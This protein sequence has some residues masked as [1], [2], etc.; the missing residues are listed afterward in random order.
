LINFC[1]VFPDRLL[2]N[3]TRLFLGIRASRYPNWK[4]MV[5]LNNI[6]IIVF[7]MLFVKLEEHVA[8][9]LIIGYLEQYGTS[10]DCPLSQWDGGLLT[11]ELTANG[12]CISFGA[13][14]YK[15]DCVAA[16]PVLLF[17]S[18]PSCSNVP[19]GGGFAGQC[20]SGGINHAIFCCREAFLSHSQ[21]ICAT[22]APTKT[23]TK[24]PTKSPTT[25]S[26]SKAPTTSNPTSSPL[27]VTHSPSTQATST[28]SS[29]TFSPSISLSAPTGNSSNT[30]AIIAGAA[31]GG[32]A[33]L[34]T[35]FLIAILVTRAK[36]QRSRN[37]Q[38]ATSTTPFITNTPSVFSSNPRFQRI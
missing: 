14:Y 5:R 38:Q 12:Q 37:D 17:F 7:S 1:S 10:S 3:Q 21:P 20:F 23:P 26:P 15:L 24:T 16:T 35:I 4:K 18:D 30:V 13:N 28:P 19:L 2:L 31:G 32:A 8:L 34:G 25:S 27:V 36:N 6:I 29:L 11:Q 33:L 22:S 9:G